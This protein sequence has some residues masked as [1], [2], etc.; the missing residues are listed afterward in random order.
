MLTMEKGFLETHGVDWGEEE[1]CRE[2]SVEGVGEILPRDKSFD[3]L[4]FWRSCRNHYVDRETKTKQKQFGPPQNCRKSSDLL[5]FTLDQTGPALYVCGREAKYRTTSFQSHVAFRCIAC[6][7][8]LSLG[9]DWLNAKSSRAQHW[10]KESATRPREQGIGKESMW[11]H[12]SGRYSILN[13]RAT[14]FTSAEGIPEQRFL[15][16]GRL[17]NH[18]LC[19]RHRIISPKDFLSP[20]P[21]LPPA[22]FPWAFLA[23]AHVMER[24]WIPTGEDSS[25]LSK[26]LLRPNCFSEKALPKLLP[27]LLFYFFNFLAAFRFARCFCDAAISTA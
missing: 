5:L 21:Y 8:E 24:T 1:V 4:I 12:H 9:D 13:K 26:G 22:F 7:R 3:I 16:T 20:S 2:L 23:L 6:D 17:F 14:I 27:I 25:H 11:R 10:T 18:A 15:F 19:L